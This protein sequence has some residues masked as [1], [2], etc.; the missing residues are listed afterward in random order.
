MDV[1]EMVG[2]IHDS[3]H[4]TPWNILGVVSQAYQYNETWIYSLSRSS[5]SCY[6]PDRSYESNDVIRVPH[7]DL[8]QKIH[9]LN[10]VAA[11]PILYWH[12]K[13][14]V[15]SN[16]WLSH[17][18]R[19]WSTASTQIVHDGQFFFKLVFFLKKKKISVLNWYPSS[20][21]CHTLC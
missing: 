21:R 15:P 1:V 20:F 2:R 13:K 5:Q 7:F 4:V 10:G 11:S 17:M 6:L 16:G 3:S 14:K 12:H 18:M 19:I 8:K 9:R